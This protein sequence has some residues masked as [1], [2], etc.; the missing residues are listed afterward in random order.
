[1][2]ADGIENVV[3]RH[4]DPAAG[5]HGSASQLL[6]RRYAPAR[7]DVEHRVDGGFA[8]ADLL[9]LAD[10]VG[11]DTLRRPG[12]AFPALRPAS[13]KSTD[14]SFVLGTT[15]SPSDRA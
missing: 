10:P 5:R 12:P 14:R 2:R 6:G 3:F 4:S 11:R 7:L 15:V 1:M 13:S 9:T 8:D